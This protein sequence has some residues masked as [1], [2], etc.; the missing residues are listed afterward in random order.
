MKKSLFDITSERLKAYSVQAGLRHSDVRQTVLEKLCLLPQPFTTEE[1]AQACEEDRISIGTIYNVLRLFVSAHIVHAIE[2]QRGQRTKTLY[3]VEADSQVKMQMICE[4]CGRV[5]YF[6]DKAIERIIRARK[7]SNFNLQQ[8][9]LFV[10][11]ECKKC[12]QLKKTKN[13]L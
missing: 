10:Y 5:S 8:F 7:Y 12:K 2:R 11:G 1:L 4:K 6:H 9:T 3:E 13:N